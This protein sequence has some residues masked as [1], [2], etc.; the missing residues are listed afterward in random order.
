MAVEHHSYLIRIWRDADPTH[1]QEGHGQVV[2][3]QSNACWTFQSVEALLALINVERY[4]IDLKKGQDIE[5]G[6]ATKLA[7]C[8]NH[9]IKNTDAMTA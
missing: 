7:S 4:E 8:K 6:T 3:I 5:E 1:H 2:Q 9:P